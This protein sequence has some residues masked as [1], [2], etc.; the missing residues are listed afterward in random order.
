MLLPALG[1]VNI[2]FM[3]YSLVADHWQY[4]SIIG[5][6]ALVVSAGVGIARRS[7]PWSFD[8]GRPVGAIVLALLTAATWERLNAY[9][10]VETLWYDTLTKN[11]QC[12]M[13]QNNLGMA[14]ARTGRWQEASR[15]FEEALQIK[16]NYA[17]GHNNLGD[18]LIRQGNVQEA[19]VQFELALRIDPDNAGAHN[20]LGNALL[21]AG[22]LQEAV[23]HYQQ[24]LRLKPNYAD[25]HNNLGL[26]LARAGHAPEAIEHYAQALWLQPDFADAYNNLARLLATHAPAER[27]DVVRAVSL[28]Q[29]ACELTDNRRAGYLDTLAAAYAA[30]GRFS[31]AVATAQKAIELARAAGPPKLV[32]EYEAR[33]ELYRSG[34]ACLQS[35]GDDESKQPLTNPSN[36]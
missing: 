30:A 10:D 29:R 12:W 13:A 22:K 21:R 17:E 27:G 24:A 9:Q 23:G 35:V 32:G 26:A 33:L 1:F 31:E 15:H 7:G 28:A 14:L 5:I 11:P 3:R 16:P 2:Y 4:F 34:H 6:I 20:N 25:A 18:T 36:R 19:I 8:L